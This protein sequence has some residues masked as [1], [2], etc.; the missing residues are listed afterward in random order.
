MQLGISQGRL[1]AISMNVSYGGSPKI[2]FKEVLSLWERSRTSPYTWGTILK[3][4]DSQYVAQSHLALK[5]ARK[6]DNK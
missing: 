2:F 6:L 4:L 1:N 3:A 5:V